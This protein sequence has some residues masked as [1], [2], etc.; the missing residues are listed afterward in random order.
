MIQTMKQLVQS[1]TCTCAAADENS[2]YYQASGRGVKPIISPMREQKS[3]FKEKYVADSIVGKAAALLF[4]LSGAKYVYGE[5]MSRTAIP[6]LEANGIE[7]EYGTLVEYT[8][9]RE[10]TGMCPLEECVKN[11]NDPAA[12]W[13][14]I[15]NRISELMRSGNNRGSV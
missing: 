4:A 10:G 6:V 13:I 5:V 7:Y 15:E 9:N 2:V 12:A 8:K 11:E 3:F 1:G 14:K